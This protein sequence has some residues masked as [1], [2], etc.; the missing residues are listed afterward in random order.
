MNAEAMECL[1]ELL[2]DDAHLVVC[3]DESSLIEVIAVMKDGRA[4]YGRF[5]T[6]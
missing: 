4:A 5:Q 6:V 2:E 3:D 1:G